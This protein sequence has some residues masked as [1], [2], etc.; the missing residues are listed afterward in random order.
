[1]PVLFFS[2]LSGVQCHGYALKQDSEIFDR[3]KVSKLS[4][5]G[6]VTSLD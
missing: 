3:E 1:M 4:L 6:T 5:L 2:C